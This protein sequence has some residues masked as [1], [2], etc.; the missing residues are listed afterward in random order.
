MPNDLGIADF[1]G[2]RVTV[3]GD[4]LVLHHKNG[5]LRYARVKMKGD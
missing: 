2:T 3:E 5:P 4:H 1:E